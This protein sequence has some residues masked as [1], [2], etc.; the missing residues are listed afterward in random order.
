MTTTYDITAVGHAIV[1]VLA[2]ADDA[3]LKSHDLHKGAMTLIDQHRA[4]SLNEA[5]ADSE[6][7]SG[8]SAGNT[9]AGAASFGA[10]CAYIGKVAHDS[11]G[12][13]FSR[14]LK[15]MGVTFNTQ[16]LHDDPTHT[17]RCLINVTPD[18]QRTM[19]TFLGAAAMVGPNDVDPELVKASQIV[20]LEGYLFDT[21]SGREAFARAA[22]IARNNGRKTAITLSDTFVVDRW[23]EDLLA[24]I[25]RHIDLVFANEHE[26]MSLFQT[27]DFD[28]ALRYLRSKV[29][30]A[31]V[32]RSE[33]GSVA[34]RQD[35]IH[36][37]PT[38]PAAA[39]L[40]TTGAG[41]Q[42]AAGVMFGLTRGLGLDVCGR[43]GS[44]AASEVIDHY[45][46]RP[47]VSLRE[48]AQKHGLI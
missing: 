16:V 20:Y 31:F 44:L 37:I 29:E 22:Q 21:P 45:G 35:E 7:A 30:L 40:D 3:F 42:Y 19:A 23:R 48:L 38:Y 32:T 41:D 14:D 43:L 9:I 12:E 13:V 46:P 27:D 5:M 47:K 28:K 25:S 34:A 36:V 10:K 15:K 2:P 8:G 11:L 1:D 4:V 33:K 6:M 39:V 17:G 26:L 24:F 18:G